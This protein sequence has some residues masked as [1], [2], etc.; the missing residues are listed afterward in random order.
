MKI[1]VENKIPFIRGVLESA[2][3]VIY[4]A[5]E[6]IDSRLV[7]DADAIFVRTRT[8]CNADLLEGSRCRFIAT[9]TIGT[10]HIDL[11]WCRSRGITVANAPGCNAPAVAQWVMAAIATRHPSPGGLTLG[12]VGAGN[13]GKIVA[14]RAAALGMNV[15]VCDPPR[16][17]REGPESFVTLDDIAA[18]ADIVTFHVP[19]T[20]DGPYP[21][22]H[23]CGRGF[24]AKVRPGTMILNAARGPVADT[25][26]L[27]EAVNEG[28]ISAAIDCW[29]GEPDISTDLLRAADIATPHI[30]GYSAEGKQRAT[31]MAVEA[32]ARTF[33][34]AK[35]NPLPFT[36]PPVGPD[37]T[38]A[39]EVTASYDIMADTAALKA[40][41]GRF[42]NLRNTYNY[43]HEN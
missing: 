27:V 40:A 35:L 26:A 25:G 23:L 31:A 11:D 21:T 7:A 2:G 1:I 10:D 30:A 9:A 15:L 19:M 41:P 17:D 22:R 18:R 36:P 28:R 32:F 34:E 13:V 20:V 14:R 5:P 8:R 29:E 43:R 24:L 42:E 38:S 4:A 37:Y 12:I 3:E 39:A 33:P 16:A 6:A